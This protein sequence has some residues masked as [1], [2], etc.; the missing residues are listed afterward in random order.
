MQISAQSGS[1]L[2]EWQQPVEFRT[3]IEAEAS[4]LDW[5]SLSGQLRVR[6]PGSKNILILPHFLIAN[7]AEFLL[8]SRIIPQILCAI[9]RNSYEIIVWH[10]TTTIGS[11]KP[12]ICEA[13]GAGLIYM[14]LAG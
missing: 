11:L 10:I 14:A 4:T 8:N 7:A 3:K 13:M 1:H 6:M 2:D 12:Q 5:S 9:F